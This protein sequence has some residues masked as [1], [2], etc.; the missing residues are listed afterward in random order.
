MLLWYN[1]KTISDSLRL[2]LLF[3]IQFEGRVTQL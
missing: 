1:H 2:I 3:D